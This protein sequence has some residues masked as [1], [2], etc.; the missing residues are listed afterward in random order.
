MIDTDYVITD[1]KR[2]AHGHVTYSYT[3]RYGQRYHITVRWADSVSASA[4][5]AMRAHIERFRQKHPVA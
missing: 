3:D 4:D 1:R 2:S 5:R